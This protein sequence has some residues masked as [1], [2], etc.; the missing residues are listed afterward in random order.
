MH[1]SKCG[2]VIDELATFNDTGGSKY[3]CEACMGRMTC[4]HCGKTIGA[5]LPAHALTNHK[6]M[7][8][9]CWNSPRCDSCEGILTSGSTVIGSK[10]YHEK[11]V[12]A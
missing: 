3:E 5:G 1:C 2:N 7:C 8:E 6:Y 4:M 12:P 9:A 10:V 11:C